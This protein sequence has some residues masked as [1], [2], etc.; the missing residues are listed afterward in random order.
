[1]LCA[2]FQLFCNSFYSHTKPFPCGT[3]WKVLAVMIFIFQIYGMWFSDRTG[4][5]FPR[6]LGTFRRTARYSIRLYCKHFSVFLK[7]KVTFLLYG[8][9]LVVLSAYFQPYVLLYCT[10]NFCRCSAKYAANFRQR[11]PLWVNRSESID[12][13]LGVS[14]FHFT[15]HCKWMTP[16][17]GDGYRSC[18]FIC[19]RPSGGQNQ[20]AM[21]AEAQEMC[22][23]SPLS[24]QM[25][26]YVITIYVDISCHLYVYHL[27]GDI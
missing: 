6:F 7:L 27:H 12:L 4:S 1:M 13:F 17:K 24:L 2:F 3:V 21:V 19:S 26:R 23:S 25:E 20:A 22:S 11:I 15:F 10:K 5:T 9:F 18:L 14:E 8:N 16:I